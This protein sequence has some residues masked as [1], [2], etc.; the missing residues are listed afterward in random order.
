MLSPAMI[1]L[2]VDRHAPFPS[3]DPFT[4]TDEATGLPINLTGATIKMEVRLYEGAAG[5]A[6][7]DKT[8][9]L[10]DAARGMFG[11]PAVTEAE[12]EG[13]IAAAPADIRNRVSEVRFRYD[14]K[15]SGVPGFPAAFIVM[16]GDYVVQTGVTL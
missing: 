6:L 5:A 4:L 3:A 12:H 11:P 8:I 9:T 16:R 15:A 13:L 2:R 7:L 1:D 14:I 10:V